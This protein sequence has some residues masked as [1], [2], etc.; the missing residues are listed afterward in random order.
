MFFFL[1]LLTISWCSRIESLNYWSLLITVNLKKTHQHATSLTMSHSQ[2]FW[3]C[4][5]SF[6][7]VFL[8]NIFPPHFFFSNS[9][10]ILLLINIRKNYIF[11]ITSFTRIP[12]F[13]V[14]DVFLY[15]QGT[16]YIRSIVDDQNEKIFSLYF[17]LYL[18]TIYSIV[19]LWKQELFV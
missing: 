13:L 12:S 7:L 17:Y 6:P 1:L 14:L 18:S 3:S 2:Y 4:R 8:S 16:T 19:E 5:C 9:L 11:N 15:P 10:S